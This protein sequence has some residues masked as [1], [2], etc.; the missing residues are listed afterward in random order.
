MS[1]M[2]FKKQIKNDRLYYSNGYSDFKLAGRNGLIYQT[3]ILRDKPLG[4]WT[5]THDELLDTYKLQYSDESYTSE[6]YAL[7]I[8]F[9]PGS[10]DR[11]GLIEIER[12]HLYTYGNADKYVYWSPM[13]LELRNLY[14]DDEIDEFS[15]HYKNDILG[16][17][18]VPSNRDQ[19][20]EFLYLNGDD[21]SWNWGRNGMTNAAF[22]NQDARNFFRNFF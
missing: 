1:F 16:K 19:I 9:H 3:W 4:G 12:I 11:I 2:F 13:M 15:E 6:N 22:I 8:D 20:V 10:N 14:Y 17:I 18:E 7:V 5:V 21:Y